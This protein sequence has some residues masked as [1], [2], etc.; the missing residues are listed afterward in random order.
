ML[1]VHLVIHE[2]N[3]AANLP[4]RDWRSEM[5]AVNKDRADIQPRP[6]VAWNEGSQESARPDMEE[7]RQKLLGIMA[8]ALIAGGG[9]ASWFVLPGPQFRWKLFLLFFSLFLEGLLV[10]KLRWQSLPGATALIVLGPI[11]SLTMALSLRGALPLPYFFSL[12]VTGGAMLNPL[13]GFLAAGLSTGGLYALRVFDASLLPPLTLLWMTAF[14]GWL[15]S[16]GLYTVLNWA[17]SSQQRA[18]QLLEELRDRRGELNRTLVALTEA[19]RRLKRTSH[20]LAL[21]RQRAEEARR[22]KEQFAANISHELR[23]PLNLILGFSEM[24]YLSPDV[25]GEMEW[26]PTL[27]RDVHQVYRSSRQ[28]LDLINDVLD[29]SRIDA[30]PMPIHRELSDLREIIHEAVDTASDLLRGRALDLRVEMPPDLPPLNLDQTRI[31]QVL[32]NLLNN[33]ARFTE[34]GHIIVSVERNKREVVVSVA[35][36]GVGITPEELSMIFEEFHQVD[37]SLRRWQEGAGLG[38]AISKRFVELHEGRIWAE[39]QVGQG[40][41]FYFSLPLPEVEF[42][43]GRLRPG[44]PTEPPRNPYQPSLVLVDED[45]AVA[46]LLERYLR[47]YQVLRME[48]LDGGKTQELIEEWHPQALILNLQPGTKGWEAMREK[49]LQIAPPRVPVLLCSLPSQKWREQETN[50][51]GWLT[52]PVYREQLLEV[53][54]RADGAREV[55]VVDDDRGFVQLVKRILEA[56]DGK[57]EVRWA[58]EGEEALA[59]I[60]EKRPDLLLLDLIMP[61]MD[62]FQLLE[63]LRGDEELRSIPVVIVT[64]TSYGEDAMAQRGSM[65]GLARGRGFD[66]KEVIEC[67]QALLD[68]IEPQYAGADSVPGPSAAPPA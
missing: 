4:Y 50:V 42:S 68:V 2:C 30:V 37:M 8:L 48:E 32:L 63:E 47:G 6:M 45:P 46:T 44:R 54:D 59:R 56:S 12:V 41:T 65:I 7:L 15:S 3:C 60:Q 26:P 31:R 39:S 35:D 36:T 21:A 24:M 25:Y 51:Q 62:G 14:M 16:R 27:R 5:A 13:L 22:L 23:T 11:A 40:S 10:Y 34:H 17:W 64:A 49:A 29:L 19:N 61:G 58:Y 38:L 66:T 57:Y 28:L 67:L 53:L 9:V 18:N 33:A 1:H 52:K 20:E 55:L 43:V